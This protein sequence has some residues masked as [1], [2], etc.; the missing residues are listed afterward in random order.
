M[1]IIDTFLDLIF[2][3]KCVG[4]QQ[5]IPGKQ[6]LC[7]ECQ[8]QLIWRDNFESSSENHFSRAYAVYDF[9]PLIQK[10][11]HDFKYNEMTLIGRF[12]AEQA[13]AFILAQN[14]FPKIDFIMPVPLH[15]VKKRFRGFNQSEV[16]TR[17]IAKNCGFSHLPNAIQR[18]RFT[19]TQTMLGRQERRQNVLGAFKLKNPQRISA[20]T[21]LL[22]D[23]VFT[24]GATV[25]S[26][27][28]LLEN[29]GV[30]QIIVLTIARA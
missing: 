6:V 5:K 18:K 29:N 2:P 7:P 8:Q 27:S 22:V 20:K 9:S 23:D 25:N 30:S 16:L 21:I 17:V 12:L 10:L 19:Q 24:T 13:S 11:I 3:R 1:K 26:I 4:C 15:R 28:N 14:D